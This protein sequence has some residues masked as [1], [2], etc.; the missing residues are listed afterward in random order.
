MFILALA[1]GS[2]A[3]AVGSH[4]NPL[5]RRPLLAFYDRAAS[6]QAVCVQRRVG[7]E[8][9]EQHST[10]FG[11]FHCQTKSKHCCKWIN[12][13]CIM[14]PAVAMEGTVCV[15]RA[16]SLF[17]KSHKDRKK[18]SL[19]ELLVANAL[20][21]VTDFLSALASVNHTCEALFCA[22]GPC[23]VFRLWQPSLWEK[24][25]CSSCNHFILV[26]KSNNGKK[27]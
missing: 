6:V 4:M 13:K 3:I 16:T 12:Q 27:V 2:P 14:S 8:T 21:F 1:G 19:L 23:L 7:V 22:V 5:R 15:C 26:T 11:R 17:K 18:W 24:R 9:E 20:Q 25:I 10:A